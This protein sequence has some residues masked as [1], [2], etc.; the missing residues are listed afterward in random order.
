MRDESLHSFE[1]ANFPR[2]NFRPRLSQ[3]LDVRNLQAMHD[4]HYGLEV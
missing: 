1:L 3:T 4:L 2:R